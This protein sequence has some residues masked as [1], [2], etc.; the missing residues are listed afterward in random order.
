M[1]NTLTS[2]LFPGLPFR[3]WERVNLDT[4]Y[5]KLDGLN[6]K[7]VID[8]ERLL[9]QVSNGGS[10]YTWGGFGEDRSELWKGFEPDR[11]RMIHLGI[12]FNNLPYAQ[13]VASIIDGTVVDIWNDPSAFNG[14]GI[15]VMIRSANTRYVYLYGHLAPT[16]V[17]VGDIV[18]AGQIVSHL[19]PPDRNGG[20]FP[21]LHLQ[22]MTDEYLDGFSSYRD[23]DG[24]EFARQV[25]EIPGLMDPLI[26]WA[27]EQ[28][29]SF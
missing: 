3:P 29:F 9:L 28:T 22:V 12:D 25:D 4:E 21:H 23:V 6:M 11:A 24:Y 1:C 7:H 8:Q 27:Q 15:R 2:V 18:S 10:V 14:W 17:Q 13:L 20:W 16:K 19:A 26:A 5:Q